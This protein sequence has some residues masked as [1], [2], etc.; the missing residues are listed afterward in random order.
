MSW[1]A[2]LTAV[3]KRLV[4]RR[5]A[6]ISMLAIMAL[7]LLGRVLPQEHEMLPEKWDEVSFAH[8]ERILL[9]DK[10][11]LTDISGSPFLYIVF[12]LLFLNLGANM[13]RRLRN[14]PRQMRVQISRKNP[15]VLQKSIC[16]RALE[17]PEAVRA[18][19]ADA[20]A[21]LE[22]HRYKT[23][24]SK[25]RLAG[26]RHRT[27]LIGSVLFHSSFV[28]I[29]IGAMFSLFG[30]FHGI[31]SL[32]VGEVFTGDR[33]SYL[34]II[35]GDLPDRRLPYL[36]FVLTDFNVEYD[37]QGNILDHVVVLRERSG[38]EHVVRV[39]EPMRRGNTAVRVSNFGFAPVLSVRE[40]SVGSRERAAI[41]K[42]EI[43]PPG[44]VD[45]FTFDDL[46]TEFELQLYPDFVETPQG[47]SSAGSQL[48]NPLAV[49]TWFNAQGNPLQV[50]LRP[51][52]P[53]M[54]GGEYFFAMPEI[55]RWVKLEL[56]R[57][58]G[59][60]PVYAGLLMALLG[61]WWRLFLPPERIDVLLT[62]NDEGTRSIHFGGNPD[63]TRMPFAG[64]FEHILDR[65]EDEWAQ[66]PRPRRSE[67]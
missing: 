12:A 57:D 19:L 4:S 66:A 13:V 36:S 64:R 38:E 43:M 26:V 5:T 52:S 34:G 54:S 11:G 44:K 18:P 55:Q 49:V 7:L 41:F 33:S 15:R 60:I 24:A 21:L 61:L 48:R 50:R 37:E 59:R 22:H 56:H 29:G 17:P 35:P 23:V 27:S 16:Y 30:R 3:R 62:E 10:L 53:P 46:P 63:Y 39:N 2:A 58:A 1:K 6:V 31:T 32:G 65:L 8:P 14:L 51:G 40:H 47:P 28:V 20:Q 9:L 45:T 42:L 67:V 25:N